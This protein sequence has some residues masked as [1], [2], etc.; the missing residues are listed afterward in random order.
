[1]F[2]LGYYLSPG[3]LDREETLIRAGITCHIHF[4]IFKSLKGFIWGEKQKFLF[5][6]SV[7]RVNTKNYK[8]EITHAFSWND[9]HDFF[10]LRSGK[11]G[12]VI[13]V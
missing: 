12:V 1:M 4:I 2:G 5:I 9:A 7:L 11:S 8:M 13:T 10:V 6:G 3:I